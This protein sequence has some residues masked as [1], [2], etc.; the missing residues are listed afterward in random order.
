V[1]RLHCHKLHHAINAHA[2][3]PMGI[4]PHGGMFTLVHVIPKDP[5]A[6][7]RHP[8]QEEFEA[9]EGGAA[10]PAAPAAPAAGAQPRQEE[11]T[12]HEGH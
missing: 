10:T 11:V 4:M 6:P 12:G 3:V 7:W 2:D 8:R 9:V 5:D 1:W